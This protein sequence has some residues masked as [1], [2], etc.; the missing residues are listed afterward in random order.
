LT[1]RPK[2]EYVWYSRGGS[3]SSLHS[4]SNLLQLKVDPGAPMTVKLDAMNLGRG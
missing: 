2:L 4:S 1:S 3:H